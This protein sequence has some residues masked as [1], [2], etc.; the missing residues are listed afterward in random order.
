[1]DDYEID[2][3]P[4]GKHITQSE[5]QFRFIFGFKCKNHCYW[6][7]IAQWNFNCKYQELH[8]SGG[9]CKKSLFA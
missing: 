2:S 7:L 6:N 8:E 3:Q 5:M 9:A 4:N 1:M